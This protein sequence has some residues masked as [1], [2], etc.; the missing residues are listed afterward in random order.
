MHMHKTRV[1]AGRGAKKTALPGEGSAAGLAAA[2]PY[3]GVSADWRGG[4]GL[5]LVMVPP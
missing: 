2:G 4:G 1:M 5:T 3:F